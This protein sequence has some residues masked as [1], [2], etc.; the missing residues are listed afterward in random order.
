MDME[1][2]IS[3]QQGPPLPP[4]VSGDLLGTLTIRLQACS[5]IDGSFARI[6]FWGSS[7][8]SDLRGASAAV[9]YPLIGSIPS[10]DNYMKD[11]SPLRVSFL[12]PSS[13]NSNELIGYAHISD[14][15]ITDKHKLKPESVTTTEDHDRNTT[16]TIRTIKLSLRREVQILSLDAV[17]SSSVGK[18]VFELLFRV[19]IPPRPQQPEQPQQVQMNIMQQQVNVCPTQ[20]VGNRQT[21]RQDLQPTVQSSTVMPTNNLPPHNTNPSYFVQGQ[22]NNS[23]VNNDSSIGLNSGNLYGGSSIEEKQSLLEE[24]LDLCTDDMTIPTVNSSDPSCIDPYDMWISRMVQHA[25][26]PPPKA[27]PS[28]VSAGSNQSNALRKVGLLKLE[29]NSLS[30]SSS[31]TD[32]LK[33]KN[34]FYIQYNPPLYGQV[35]NLSPS[36]DQQVEFVVCEQFSSG[37]Q[38]NKVMTN[39]RKASSSKV[40]KKKLTS[41]SLLSDIHTKEMNVLFEN[42]EC[43]RQWLDGTIK[44]DLFCR[45]SSTAGHT[46][47]LPRV[48]MLSAAKRKERKLGKICIAQA[49]LKLCDLLLSNTLTKDVKLDLL[50]SE[51]DDELLSDVGKVCSAK[52][53]TMSLRL[54]LYPGNNKTT[55]QP[56]SPP[57]CQAREVDASGRAAHHERS[58]PIMVNGFQPS[59]AMS[60]KTPHPISVFL[61]NFARGGTV[62][63]NVA[64]TMPSSTGK[65][66]QA[67]SQETHEKASSVLKPVKA[68]PVWLDVRIER[69][70]KSL[71]LDTNA[72]IKIGISCNEPILSSSEPINSQKTVDVPQTNDICSWQIALDSA[73]RKQDCATIVTLH[74]YRVDDKSGDASSKEKTL[75]GLV[76]I[77]FII[78]TTM[79]KQ[80][81]LPAIV[82][83]CWLDMLDPTSHTTKG[84]IQVLIVAGMLRQVRGFSLVC[85]S[86]ITIQKWW[87]KLKSASKEVAKP[88]VVPESLNISEI[89]T[90]PA[91]DTSLSKDEQEDVIDT[92]HEGFNVAQHKR[93]QKHDDDSPDSLFEDWSQQSQSLSMNMHKLPT[94]V[95]H[96]TSIGEEDVTLDSAIDNDVEAVPSVEAASLKAESSRCH[97]QDD[98]SSLKPPVL[99]VCHQSG[100]VPRA[101]IHPPMSTEQTTTTQEDPIMSTIKPMNLEVSFSCGQDEITRR[102]KGIDPPEEITPKPPPALTRVP[103]APSNAK[104]KLDT[105]SSSDVDNEETTRVYKRYRLKESTATQQV[106]PPLQPLHESMNEDAANE[107]AQQD[108]GDESETLCPSSSDAASF[109]CDDDEDSDAEDAL[110]YRSL[111]SMIGSLD[112]IN[113]RLTRRVAPEPPPERLDQSSPSDTANSSG[114]DVDTTQPQKYHAAPPKHHDSPPQQEPQGFERLDSPGRPKIE[115]PEEKSST[116]APKRSNDEKIVKTCEKGISTTKLLYA[117]ATTSPSGDSLMANTNGRVDDDRRHQKRSDIATEPEVHEQDENDNTT[118]TQAENSDKRAH[119]SLSAAYQ[120]RRGQ[121]TNHHLTRGRG[122]SATK[123]YSSLLSSQLRGN[124]SSLSPILLNPLRSSPF[125]QRHPSRSP[126]REIIQK[127]KRDNNSDVNENKSLS[128]ERL[129]QIFKSK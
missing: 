55:N 78:N 119:T 127:E 38:S 44:F 103:K 123:R 87:K 86:T 106:N 113:S 67:P 20:K 3:I 102:P 117:D 10:L 17:S 90:T 93:R 43:V 95:L 60:S 24:L 28:L 92:I 98:D 6:Q 14:M 27:F 16:A 12:R 89:K 52:V 31:V 107:N 53:G 111:S 4:K 64:T 71:V 19:I 97:D 91:I 85:K 75:F 63:D 115:P 126:L 48:A 110:T 72:S 108:N 69:L 15:S 23:S 94:S 46:P 80:S 61:S 29:I 79:P 37:N 62:N 88:K 25:S 82:N 96:E 81:W 7:E 36:L 8:Y 26:S 120:P 116:P 65:D 5:I 128:K 121:Y 39:N 13:N 11:A 45:P 35:N 105:P 50:L 21:T 34:D 100:G 101:N 41:I 73:E 114:M 66:R 112:D 122:S 118:T 47:K 32:K 42:D 1:R 104:R 70:S 2:P 109:D 68:P 9:E 99:P 83:N 129:E 54:G 57:S 74:I 84:K 49:T 22:S 76:K 59:S 51:E 40:A 58:A 30:L 124:G 56:S 125:R 77:P 18:A 33:G